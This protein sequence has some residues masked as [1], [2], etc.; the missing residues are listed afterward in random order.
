M[1]CRTRTVAPPE[2]GNFCWGSDRGKATRY[3]R[4]GC[5]SGRSVSDFFLRMLHTYRQRF[6][7]CFKHNA[8][9]NFCP[10]VGLQRVPRRITTDE[11][12]AHPNR[13]AAIARETAAEA[14]CCH[15]IRSHRH[16]RL[17]PVVTRLVRTWG[18]E[19]H[20]AVICLL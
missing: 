11:Q 16:P 8:S 12:C 9:E 13:C 3:Y 4:P 20:L 5:N 1:V 17:Q 19:P 2:A 15:G 7:S 6:D 18:W 14:R 10:K